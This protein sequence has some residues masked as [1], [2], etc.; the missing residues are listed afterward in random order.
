M[1]H[2]I[3][4]KFRTLLWQF[5]HPKIIKRYHFEFYYTTAVPY[6]AQRM[7]ANVIPLIDQVI[8]PNTTFGDIGS[9][10]G[11]YSL[12]CSPKVKK[13]CAYEV[14]FDRV[15]DLLGNIDLNDFLN[16]QPNPSKEKLAE[17]DVIKIDIDGGELDYLRQIDLRK[18]KALIVEMNDKEG[19]SNYLKSIDYRF[20]DKRGHNWLWI[21][22]GINRNSTQ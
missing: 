5:A 14:D 11:F 21:K 18:N 7:G 13:V 19:L 10:F 9:S 3:Y 20:K 2:P 17:C 12:Y 4:D 15:M 6:Y 1:K 16:I 22:N 8:T